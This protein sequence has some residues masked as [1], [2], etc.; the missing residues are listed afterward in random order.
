MKSEMAIKGERRMD[1]GEE[2]L[3]PLSSEAQTPHPLEATHSLL[4]RFS[5][6]AACAAARVAMGMRY[7]EQLT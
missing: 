2:N 4:D 1:K 6:I 5:F 7:G 3:I